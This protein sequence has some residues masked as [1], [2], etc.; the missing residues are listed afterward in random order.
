MIFIVLALFAVTYLFFKP[1]F[2][3]KL[4]RKETAVLF[5]VYLCVGMVVRTILL[6]FGM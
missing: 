5:I 2:G 6:I 1:A 3:R 4:S